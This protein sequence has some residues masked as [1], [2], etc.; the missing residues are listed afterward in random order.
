MDA[1]GVIERLARENETD[2]HSKP[3][4]KHGDDKSCFLIK[5]DVG[6]KKQRYTVLRLYGLAACL[7]E[8]SSSPDGWQRRFE[9]ASARS[10]RLRWNGSMVLR[11]LARR[12]CCCT[13]GAVAKMHHSWSVCFSRINDG[14]SL[15]RKTGHL[16]PPIPNSHPPG[17]EM[18]CSDTKTQI[19]YPIRIFFC[20]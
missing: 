15:K 1:R 10:R 16:P 8:S 13:P 18:I 19:H 9:A 14:C 20:N 2:L 5:F 11:A 12:R 7:W 6:E 17:A 4:T 3:V